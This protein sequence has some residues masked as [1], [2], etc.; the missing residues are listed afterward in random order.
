MKKTFLMLMAVAVM[1]LGL[2][3]SKAEITIPQVPEELK[4]TVDG[5]VQAL[6]LNPANE[7]VMKAISKNKAI[8]KNKPVLVAIGYKFL[9]NNL[10][11]N[12]IG[13]AKMVYEMDPT[14]LPAI[15][16]EGDAYFKMANN[17]AYGMAA[18]KYEEAKQVDPNSL[19]P[20]LKL[21]GVYRYIN[22]DYA[23]ELMQEIRN[24]KTD[25]PK[26]NQVL[27]TLYYQLADT[28]NA[29][30]FYNKYFATY[31][32]GQGDITVQ[33]EYAII[34][35][36]A[37]DYTNALAQAN[38]FLQTNPNDPVLRRIVF[39]SSCELGNDSL[40]QIAHDRYFGQYADS[41][42]QEIDYR[43]EGQF[44]NRIQNYQGAIAAYK[45]AAK[46][47]T[48]DAATQYNLS[49]TYEKVK[50][51]NDAISAYKRYMHL[52]KKDS[53]VNEMFRLGR[54]YYNAANNEKDS[55]SRLAFIHVG[56]SIYG[57][58]DDEMKKEGEV[59]YQGVF[60]RSRINQLVD[61]K[62]PN[63]VATKYMIEATKR[64]SDPKFA[65]EDYNAHRAQAYAYIAWYDMDTEKFA[66]ARTNADL[67]L[68]NDSEQPLA[69][70][71]IKYLNL[72]GK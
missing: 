59:S 2:Q 71:V 28:V 65:G 45:A 21:V 68:K 19:D 5:Y 15:Y 41:V 58:V 69:S 72:I 3:T 4:V 38:K 27:G 66:D 16:L 70:N 17:N 55:L 30:E 9:D 63:E 34:L 29:R 25:D 47:D 67:A 31:P 48:T 24:K 44:Y 33:R 52:A 20:Y 35:F 26:I 50:D 61:K 37:K 36:M 57:V 53:D 23:I 32:D 40:T 8:K 10:F 46:I 51:Y 39:L 60:W 54:V 64:L 1:V 42:Y 18:T 7:D 6:L 11:G 22:P 14:Y 43:Y 56:D 12:A 13:L 62:K 49:K